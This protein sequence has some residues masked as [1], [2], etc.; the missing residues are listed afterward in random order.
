MRKFVG[1]GFQQCRF[2][3]EKPIRIS[4]KDQKIR[5]MS[6]KQLEKYLRRKEHSK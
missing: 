5:R 6:A 1:L 4:K 3:P 2:G